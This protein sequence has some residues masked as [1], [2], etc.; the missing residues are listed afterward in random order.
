MH[1]F[2]SVSSEKHVDAD[3]TT[4]KLHREYDQSNYRVISLI[5]KLRIFCV[6]PQNYQHFFK[7]NNVIILMQII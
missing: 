4:L 6:L 7:K 1:L 3:A 2:N 5:L